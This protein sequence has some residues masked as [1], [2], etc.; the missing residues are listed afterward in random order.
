G[1]AGVMI[2]FFIG[3]PRQT[4]RSVEET[5]EYC[6][7]LLR[8]FRGQNVL[9]LICPMVPF[10][11]PGSRFFEEPEQHGY[12]IFH[13]TLDEHRRAMLEPLWHRRLNYETEW[14]SRRELQD[15]SY[16]AIDRLVALKGE[17]GVLPASICRTISTAIGETQALLAEIERA[18]ELDG[19]LP[20][21]L[22]ATIR[23]YN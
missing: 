11:D 2:W 14:M 22:R 4:P 13:R 10:L 15:V 3:M 7:H 18:L 5:V 1:V 17:A 9:P 20:A 8:K 16:R 21:D 12:R 19:A 6:G 23:A